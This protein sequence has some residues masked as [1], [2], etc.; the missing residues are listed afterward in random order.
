MSIKALSMNE[1]IRKNNYKRAFDITFSIF[2]I[3]FSLPIL[4]IIALLIKVSSRGPIFFS[5]ERV[6]L[7]G[8]TFRCLKFRTMV[9]DGE[10]KLKEILEKNPEL[11]KEWLNSYKLKNDPRITKIGHFL[12]KT[13][14]DEV[15]QFFNVLKGEM[16]VVGPRPMVKTEIE[17]H[18][19]HQAPLILSVRPGVTGLWQVTGRNDVDYKTRICLDLEYIRSQSFLLDLKIIAKTFIKMLTRDG[20]Y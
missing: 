12:R 3:V 4:A 8:Q 5:H 9:K 7:N 14:L 13:S 18:I 15:P 6:G 19:K 2:F 16:S 11:K 1:V 10:K 17:Q 20:A